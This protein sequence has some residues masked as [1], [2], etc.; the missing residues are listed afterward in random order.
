MTKATDD[1]A[2]GEAAVARESGLHRTLGKRQITMIGL[3]GA[4]GTGLFM[5]S[6]IAIGYAGP[7]VLVSYAIAALIAVVMVFSLSEMAVVHPT[8]GSFGTYAEIYLGRFAGF[9]IRYTYWIQQVL[10]IGSEAV[11]IGVYFRFWFPDLPVWLTGMVFAG[12]LI[13]LNSR[14][15]RNFASVEYWLTVIKVTAILLFILLGGSRILG[16]TGAATGLHNVTGLPGG[17]MPNGFGG[18][19]M[20]VLMALFSFLGL[21]FVVATAGEA[22]NPREA[23]P[24]AL[25][26]MAARLFI[27]YILALFI[28]IAFLPWTDAGAKVVTQSPFV[29]M[30]GA[31]GIPYA[32]GVMNFV[33]ASAALSAMNTSLFLASRMLFSLARG[34]YAPRALGRLNEGGVPLVATLLS[35]GCVVLAASLAMLTPLAYNY[36]FGIA[37]FGGILTWASILASH[38][39]FRRRHAATELPVR[40]PFFPVAQF[41]GLALLAAITVTMALD[42]DFWD[43]AVIAGV[44]WCAFVALVYWSWVRRRMPLDATV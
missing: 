41:I 34:G 1:I 2:A 13:W 39:V 3:G 20:G 14:P 28:I 36:L 31:V 32:A 42:R 38:L 8:A 19:W 27:F 24:A 15:V 11:A 23:I 10:L 30:F 33:V 25:G 4:I 5:G 35:G 22:E 6:G 26:T 43:V 17:F 16:L 40:M 7:A 44:P 21:E 18:V 12:G 9:L 29:R 37:L